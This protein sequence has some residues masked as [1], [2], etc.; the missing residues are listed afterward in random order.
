MFQVVA[1]YVRS[2][3]LT[4]ALKAVVP[5][6]MIA[7]GAMGAPT[8]ASAD[9]YVFDRGDMYNYRQLQLS[10]SGFST[11]TVKAA[12]VLFDGYIKGT[13]NEPFEN[14]VAF[15][16]D[17]YHGISLADYNPDLTY[18][19]DVDL[20]HNSHWDP[21]KQRMLTFEEK[22]HIGALVNYGTEIW[23]GMAT[24]A[25]RYNELAAVQGA[26]WKVV[27]RLNVTAV[28]NNGQ[29]TAIQNRLNALASA[30]N[31]E[32]AFIYADDEV[33]SRIKLLTPFK[34][35]RYG[36]KDYPHKDLT[37]SF[38]IAGPIPEPAT[39]IMM[40]GGF[41]VAGG[42]LRRSRALLAVVRVRH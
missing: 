23:Y 18:T 27:S 39:W 29:N 6:A 25:A 38:A 17:V 2:G 34:Q 26:I 16:V 9:A 22:V 10:G 41:A 36:R 20:L 3:P 5:A 14:L 35:T 37:Q 32:S 31:Y 11:V 15:C 28:N 19:D 42:M 24:G 40:I 33:S 4:G 12:P 21:V 30:A 8:V 7:L 1:D 13:P